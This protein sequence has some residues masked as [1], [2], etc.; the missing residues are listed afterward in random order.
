MWIIDSIDLYQADL[1]HADLRFHKGVAYAAQFKR[2]YYKEQF[3]KLQY[4]NCPLWGS[5]ILKTKELA[6][7]G[8]FDSCYAITYSDNSSSTLVRLKMDSTIAKPTSLPL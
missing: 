3:H 2:A 5:H 4:Q 6:I 1:S 8:S 7:A